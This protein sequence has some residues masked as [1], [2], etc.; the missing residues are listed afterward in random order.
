MVCRVKLSVI[1]CGASGLLVRRDACSISA[2]STERCMERDSHYLIKHST[3]RDLA[4]HAQIHRGG[5]TVTT[6]KLDPQNNRGTLNENRMLPVL[7]Y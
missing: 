1:L 4:M 5:D 2:G 6:E 3:G 7:Q